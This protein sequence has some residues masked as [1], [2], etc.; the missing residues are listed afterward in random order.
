MSEPISV[1]HEAI[2]RA[3]HERYG[4]QLA[5]ANQD[6]A[7]AMA[8]LE[9][10]SGRYQNQV[11]QNHQVVA[12][13]QRLGEENEQLHAE[14]QRRDQADKVPPAPEPKPEWQPGDPLR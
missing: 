8:G 3:L 10:V 9:E 12:A 14:I 6:A 4:R 5:Q 7:E 1:P 11:A 13:N 2:I